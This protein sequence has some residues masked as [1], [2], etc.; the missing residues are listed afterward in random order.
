[1]ISY[2]DKNSALLSTSEDHLG[3]LFAINRES[4]KLMIPIS[5]NEMICIETGLKE[6]RIV[7]KPD[8]NKYKIKN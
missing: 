5:Y 8:L 4:G 2:G 1:M 7:A 3:V 6:K